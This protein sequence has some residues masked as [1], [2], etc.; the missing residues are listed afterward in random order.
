MDTLYVNNRLVYY[1]FANTGSTT[2]ADIYN[3]HQM[4]YSHNARIAAVAVNFPGLGASKY[5][6]KSDDR[7]TLVLDFL[8]NA[9]TTHLEDVANYF[10]GYLERSDLPFNENTITSSISVPG[11]KLE[12]IA[13][14]VCNERFPGS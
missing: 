5:I 13:G 10:K 4:T 8:G 9:K 14:I 6:P 12:G 2:L 11:L 1:F 7:F 3:L